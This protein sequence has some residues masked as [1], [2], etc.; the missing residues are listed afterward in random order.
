MERGEERKGRGGGEIDMSHVKEFVRLF[1]P[2]VNPFNGLL[3]VFYGQQTLIP[4]QL[5]Y[6]ASILDSRFSGPARVYDNLII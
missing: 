1:V 3:N 2:C 6:G 4:L 5:F